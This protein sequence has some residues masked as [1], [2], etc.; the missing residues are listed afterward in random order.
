MLIYRIICLKVTKLTNVESYSIF[1]RTFF[2]EFITL[3]ARIIV[4]AFCLLTTNSLAQTTLPSTGKELQSTLIGLEKSIN[5]RPI[6]LL[7]NLR[8]LAKRYAEIGDL[9]KSLAFSL[10][11]LSISTQLERIPVRQKAIDFLLVGQMEFKIDNIKEAAECYERFVTLNN[12][13]DEPVL[14]GT[15][16]ADFTQ[17]LAELEIRLSDYSKASMYLNLTLILKEELLGKD[18]L[19][20]AVTLDAL[21]ALYG[22][23]GN[24][25]KAFA[26]AE[27]GLK[28]REKHLPPDDVAMA[29]SYGTLGT[30]HAHKKNWAES[31]AFFKRAYDLAERKIGPMP[32]EIAAQHRRSMES[33]ENP[34]HSVPQPQAD[35][36]KSGKSDIV[37]DPVLQMSLAIRFMETG[38]HGQ[39]R[40]FAYKSLRLLLNDKNFNHDLLAN[41]LWG[42]SGVEFIAGNSELGIYFGKL[43]I[44]IF[45]SLRENVAKISSS[46]RR[47]FFQKKSESYRSLIFML[48][49][50]GRLVEAQQVVSMMKEDEYFDFIQK[51]SR[52]DPRISRAV[53]TDTERR[54]TQIL[55][56]RGVELYQLESQRVELDNKILKGEK[57]DAEQIV[58]LEAEILRLRN[59]FS[60][61]LLLDIK[62]ERKSQYKSEYQQMVKNSRLLN[63]SSQLGKGVVILQYIVSD[64]GARVILTGENTLSARDIATTKTDLLTKVFQFSGSMHPSRDPMPIARDLYD[65]LIA[66]VAQDIK[67]LGATTIMISP[68]D[69]LRYLPFSAL[70]DGKRYLIEQYRL[71]M[72]NDVVKDNSY[73]SLNRDWRVAGF[74][75][76]RQHQG[77]EPLPSVR[78][79]IET[80]VR[81][82]KEQDVIGIFPGKIFL[83]QDFTENEL[84]NSLTPAFPVLHIASHFRF[85]PGGESESYLLLGD[86]RRLSLA[87]L[88]KGDWNFGFVDLITL[89]ACETAKGGDHDADGR[90]IEGLAALIQNQGAKGIIATLWRVSDR[91]TA[92]LMQNFYRFRQDKLSKA[93]ALRQAQLSLI[94]SGASKGAA[95][96]S[97]DV[98]QFSRGLGHPYYWA[99]FVLMGNWL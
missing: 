37:D 35:I 74:G 90:E 68:D 72:F 96:N 67:R 87:D 27:R 64:A 62:K 31:R 83:D 93:E 48:I 98:R 11:A 70:H 89:S 29:L 25:P 76:T 85:Q 24:F 23:I 52:S 12:L 77:F 88:R 4:V 30:I 7:E 16:L 18:H 42:T 78:S 5:T 22:E 15:V 81:T 19:D 39:A 57:I 55:R 84:R 45:Q 66:P 6:E 20:L 47:S 71:S 2:A 58:N 26:I 97:S 32:E 65:I 79:E 94:E 53:L 54:W 36:G 17:G 91:S 63:L 73:L 38:Q 56:D 95:T 75:V 1:S 80:I 86:G 99:P 28:I 41:V 43:A 13:A 8:G 82:D 14:S 92:M 60:D 9:Q 59:A 69:A 50:Q 33:E 51:D 34:S 3:A 46:T 49:T 44:N 40:E 21:A 10:K 61:V